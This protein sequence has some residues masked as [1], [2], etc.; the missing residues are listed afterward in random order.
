MLPS[1]RVLFR[2]SFPVLLTFFF[3]VPFRNAWAQ[4]QKRGTSTAV[5]HSTYA[6]S[7]SMF[8]EM[9]LVAPLFLQ[10]DQIDSSIT[11]VN[12]ITFAV[13]GTVTL[14]DQSGHSIGSQVISF[15]SHSSTPIVMKT[16]L[17]QVGS[18]AHSG[19]VTITQD[20]NV[21]GPALLAQLSMSLHTGSQDAF[22]EEEFGMPTAHGSTVLQGVASQT[23]NLPFVAITSVSDATQTIQATCVGENKLPTAIELPARG[24]A[25]V[26]ACSWQVI[27]DTALNLSSSLTS[28]NSEGRLADHAVSIKSDSVAGSFY[29]FGLALNAGL[30]LAQLQPLDFYDPGTLPSN[31]TVYV[32]VP[33]GASPLLSAALSAPVVTLANFSTQP[34]QTSIT[35][36]DSSSGSPKVQQIASISLAPLSTQTTTLSMVKGEGVLNTFTI[37]S[38]GRPG[39][40][41]AHLYTTVGNSPQRIELLTKDAQD[42]HNGGD[43][44]VV[45]SQWRSINAAAL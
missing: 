25:V 18:Q 2:Y 17:A 20:P 10:T 1:A 19:S 9:P 45:H 27:P 39:D 24:T 13:Q 32:G 42:D 3:T 36:S 5:A 41:H 44:P 15:P 37:T 40:V 33:L 23:R 12:A 22:L 38:D 7:E 11:V 31:G 14:R 6:A 34:K 28:S 29:A 43:H 35:W 21:K 4:T 16:I 26:Q 8:G 30:D